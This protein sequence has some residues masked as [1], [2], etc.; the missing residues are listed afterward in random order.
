MKNVL[1]YVTLT[2]FSILLFSSLGGKPQ[3]DPWGVWNQH[4][5]R[6][7]GRIRTFSTG[8]YYEEPFGF[9]IVNHCSEAIAGGDDFP[10]IAH[11]GEYIEIEK[12]EPIE[13]GFVFYLVGGGFKSIIGNTVF[14][15]NTRIQVKM[16]FVN[17]DECYFKYISLEDENGFHLSY[18][19]K[20]NVIYK[21]LRLTKPTQRSKCKEN[22]RN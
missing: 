7:N 10:A 15:D 4:P 21:R 11:P 2:V 17:D 20:E 8:K 16:H 5:F 13:D 19:V 12:Y 6:G 3:Y 1:R 18:I 14:Q 22:R 9:Y